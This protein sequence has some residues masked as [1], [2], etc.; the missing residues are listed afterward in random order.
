MEKH[1]LSVRRT[2]RYVTLGSLNADT[3]RIWFVLHGYGQLAEYFIRRFDVLDDGFTYIVAPEA[4]SRFYLDGLGAHNKVGATWMTREDRMNEI[5]DY[6]QYLNMLY[7]T[8]LGEADENRLK[9]GLLGFSQGTATACRWAASSPLQ[10]DRLVLWAGSFP[11]ELPELPYWEKL[12]NIDSLLVYGNEDFFI[13]E[14]E[15][16]KHQ[17][18]WQKWGL[19]PRIIQFA[20]K[21]EIVRNVVLK[22]MA[23]EK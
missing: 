7:Q 19:S 6:V 21:H 15:I 4:L 5:E 16:A 9:I 2:A 22:V 1:E 23:G 14:I 8:V 18:E 10:F 17:A 12:K 20:G 13:N 11:P 3:R